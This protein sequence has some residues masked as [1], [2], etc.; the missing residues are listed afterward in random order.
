V[1]VEER[2][3]KGGGHIV[4]TLKIEFGSFDCQAIAR[5]SRLFVLPDDTSNDKESF[6]MN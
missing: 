5:I 2:R 6:D 4:V 3:G 1:E